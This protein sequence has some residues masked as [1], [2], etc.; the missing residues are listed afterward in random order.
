M[1]KEVFYAILAGILIGLFFAVGSWKLTKVI[2]KKQ[3]VVKIQETP[4]INTNL[5]LI[6]ENLNDFDV[7]TKPPIVKGLTKPNSKLIISTD[8]KDILIT[9]LDDGSFEKEFDLLG[10]LNRVLFTVIDNDNNVSQKEV[11]LVYTTEL[12]NEPTDQGSQVTKLTS[13]AGTVTDIS[14]SSLQLKGNAGTILQI[15][16]SSD[17]TYINTLK[18]NIEIKS[19]D[20]AIGDYVLALGYTNNAD[21]LKKSKVLNTKRIL[22]TSPLPENKIEVKKVTIEKMTKTSINDIIL[23]KKWFGPDIKDLKVGQKIFVVGTV[24]SDKFTL[25][26]IFTPVE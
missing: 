19:T 12:E 4:K 8:E 7:W 2:K 22:V 21:N 13:Y 15:S 16:T 14:G 3:P 25:R 11:K 9:T 17:T 10:G 5:S 1:R 20:L 24:E 6:I 18:K 26:S 23:P